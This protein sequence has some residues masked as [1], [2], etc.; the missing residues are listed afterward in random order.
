[1]LGRRIRKPTERTGEADTRTRILDAAERLVAERGFHGVSLREIT[2]A[3]GANTAAVH[4]YFQHKE[5]LLEAVVDRRA[6][7]VVQE[8]LNRMEALLAGPGLPTLEALLLAYVSPGLTI[9]FESQELRKHFG[10]L[11]AR[12]SHETDPAMR[13]I[14]RRHFREPG[15]CFIV[16]IRKMLPGLTEIEIEWR[17]HFM[18]GTLIYLMSHAGRTQAVDCGPGTDHYNPDD[19]EEALRFFIPMLAAI[20]RAPLTNAATFNAAMSEVN[21]A[22]ARKLVEEPKLTKVT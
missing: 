5:D 17:F 8:R 15:H 22:L 19:M 6:G 21:D 12:F 13:A 2:A 7:I 10:R 9:C 18:I 3:A 16:A 4:S 14:M 11:R 20:F 1:M